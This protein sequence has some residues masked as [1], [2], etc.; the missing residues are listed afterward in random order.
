MILG[1]GELSVKVNLYC[2]LAFSRGGGEGEPIIRV[3]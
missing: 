2:C 3:G 1:G